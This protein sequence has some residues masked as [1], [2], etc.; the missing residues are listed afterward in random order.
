MGERVPVQERHGR[1][2][3]LVAWTNSLELC[4]EE[5]QECMCA[6]TRGLVVDQVGNGFRDREDAA[7]E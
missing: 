1:S 2:D 4:A 3:P 7:R 5:Q 6:S